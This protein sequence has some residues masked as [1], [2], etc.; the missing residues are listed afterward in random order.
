[1]PSHTIVCKLQDQD[2]SERIGEIITD[3]AP[4][5][6]VWIFG[7]P[8]KA[9][10]GIQ[11]LSRLNNNHYSKRFITTCVEVD[12][13]TDDN[14]PVEPG[15]TTSSASEVNKDGKPSRKVLG[16]MV[17]FQQSEEVDSFW[18][19]KEA[20]GWW[21]GLVVFLKIWFVMFFNIWPHQ[22]HLG[23]DHFYIQDIAVH[24]E[25]RGRGVGSK[26]INF[27]KTRFQEHPELG[28]RS[29]TL[30]VAHYNTNARR[31]YERLGFA[32]LHSLKDRIQLTLNHRLYW[33]CMELPLFE[34]AAEGTPSTASSGQ[35]APQS[36]TTSRRPAA[37]HIVQR[38]SASTTK[39]QS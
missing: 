16:V 27:T 11:A 20:F 9:A 30:D 12:D 33:T 39:M 23:Y 18:D 22:R 10:K 15:T 2:I 24:P 19:Y 29:L 28:V 17:G 21:Y 34:D 13:G 3:I 1:M 6:F 38:V 25:A 7:S 14:Q 8:E 5:D 36:T 26:I 37:K 32:P 4:E 31:L 35:S